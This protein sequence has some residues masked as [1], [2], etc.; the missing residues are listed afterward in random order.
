[1][2]SLVIE[3]SDGSFVDEVLK[4]PQ[5]VLV[6]FWAA[7]CAPCRAIAPAVETVAAEYQGRAKVAKLN[8]D[9]NPDS[10]VR[11]GVKGIPTLIVFKNGSEAARVVGVPP[12][13]YEGI[14]E[15]L[16]KHATPEAEA[17]VRTAAV[18]NSA[19]G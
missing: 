15:L 4:S 5:P 19:R 18:D 9:D 13:G 6:D 16:D 3:V 2:S 10:T 14:A 1:M 12:N 17:D 7:W 11:Y 8:V